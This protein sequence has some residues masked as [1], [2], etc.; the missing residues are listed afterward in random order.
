MPGWRTPTTIGRVEQFRTEAFRERGR[1]YNVEYRIIR[2]YGELRWVETRCFLSLSGAGKPHRV[3]EEQQRKLAE[4]DHR[5]KN[6]LATVRRCR[7][8]HLASEQI[9][10][11]FRR[12]ARWTHS[13]DDNDTRT[14]ELPSARCFA[15]RGWGHA[16]K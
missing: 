5:A 14:V 9:S 13:F 16:I 2:P 12:G 11:R 1:E 3:V 6:A 10:R 4:L 7:L 15:E 8:P